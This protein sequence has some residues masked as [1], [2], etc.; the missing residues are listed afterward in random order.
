MRL[1][2]RLL[3]A[4]LALALIAGSILLI[5]EVVADRL[6]HRPAIVHWHHLYDWAKRTEWQQGSVRVGCIVLVVIGLALLIAELKRPRV[7][8]MAVDNDQDGTAEIDTAYTRRG[9]AATVRSAVTAVDGVNGA[10]VK[11][12][13][14]KLSVAAT[15]AAKDETAVQAMRDAV[16]A[17]AQQRIDALRLRSAPSLSIHL[18]PRSN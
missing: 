5:I 15:T 10:R 3:A 7:S 17:A 9:V 13:R 11:V 8:R 2:N 16:S 1:L 12:G 4:L 6:H 18:S 14:R